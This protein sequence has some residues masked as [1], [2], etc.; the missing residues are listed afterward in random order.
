MGFA[1]FQNSLS[2]RRKHHY[3]VRLVLIPL[4]VALVCEIV[5][6]CSFSCT[7]ISEDLSSLTDEFII[8][9]APQLPSLY[10]SLFFS[11]EKI[12]HV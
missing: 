6:I 8:F 12:A 5:H 1:E 7:Y 2:F 3:H 11:I 9:R 10:I 4:R